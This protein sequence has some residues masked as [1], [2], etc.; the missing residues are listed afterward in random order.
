[1]TKG[2]S[3]H[4]PMTPECLRRHLFDKGRVPFWNYDPH[5]LTIGVEVEYF[6]ASGNEQDFKLATQNQYLQVRDFL[7]SQRG[8]QDRHLED[9]P[10]RI[11][12]DTET[13]YIAIKPD[14][15][16]H[17][18][19]IALP[20]RRNTSEIGMLLVEV[21]LDIDAALASVGLKRLDLSCLP[22]VPEDM[23]ILELGRLKSYLHSPTNSKFD[24][25]YRLFPA[26]IAATHIH[27]NCSDENSLRWLPGLYKLDRNVKSL[28]VR[29]AE[30]E[31]KIFLNPR[32]YFYS[33]ALGLNYGLAAVPETIPY[34]IETYVDQYN[35]TTRLFPED[36]FFP[37]RDLSFIRPTKYGTLEFRS[38]C[39][40]NSVEKILKIVNIRME[41]LLECFSKYDESNKGK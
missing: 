36:K 29:P 27:L 30:F 1:M 6:I 33:N 20:P 2:I 18:L 41:H 23:E 3:T 26:L 8:Y 39:S 37:A 38:A 14:F 7:I 25:A 5:K 40:F 12:K 22:R 35:K 19:E 4:K 16:W 34:S 10:G 24:S 17:I 13:G 31:G 28:I 9:Q 11:S 15:A 21:F 32:E